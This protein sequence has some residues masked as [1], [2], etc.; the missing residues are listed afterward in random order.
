M[1]IIKS[2]EG[3]W[4]NEEGWVEHE[5]LA[6]KFKNTNCNLPFGKNVKW[7]KIKKSLV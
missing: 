6:T 5:A 3:Y 7:M 1:Y 4:S 2:I